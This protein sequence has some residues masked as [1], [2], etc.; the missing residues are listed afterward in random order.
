[1]TADESHPGQRGAETAT[2][3]PIIV[4]LDGSDACS[5]L[6]GR[7]DRTVFTLSDSA[8]LVV[9][10]STGIGFF[11]EMVLGSTAGA[12]ARRHRAAAG[13]TARGISLRRCPR[14]VDRRL[15]HVDRG[16]THRGPGH[17]TTRLRLRRHDDLV[18]NDRIRRRPRP[19]HRLPSSRNRSKVG[20]R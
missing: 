13:G 8:E 11:A 19:H 14:G 16:R 4:G 5:Q 2:T 12:L 6:E 10:G 18:G 17:S 3:K 20:W 1:M 7:L 9:I 15:R